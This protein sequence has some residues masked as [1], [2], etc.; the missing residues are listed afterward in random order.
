MKKGGS[1]GASDGFRAEYK[2]P[3]SRRH[4]EE[5]VQEADHLNRDERSAVTEVR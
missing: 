5:D 2:S 4:P 3:V 1:R